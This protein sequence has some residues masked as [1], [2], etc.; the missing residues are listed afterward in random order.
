V[1]TPDAKI[2]SD[3]APTP[4]LKYDDE[5]FVPQ[6]NQSQPDASESYIAIDEKADPHPEFNTKS[7]LRAGQSTR[8]QAGT[9]RVFRQCRAIKRKPRITSRRTLSSSPLH[10]PQ[11]S[12]VESALRCYINEQENS[13]SF[14]RWMADPVDVERIA[15]SLYSF[16]L[17]YSVN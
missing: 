12:A 5:A 7:Y 2:P 11:A 9:R 6:A 15:S 10:A 1:R 16:G 14:T 17:D 4:P 8:V 3:F 13:I